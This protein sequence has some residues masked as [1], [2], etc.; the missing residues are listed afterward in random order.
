MVETIH[1]M[2]GE[3]R[4][5][6]QAIELDTLA[7]S[8]EDALK[9]VLA[10]SDL[11]D[12]EYITEIYYVAR[13]SEETGKPKSFAWKPFKKWDGHLYFDVGLAPSPRASKKTEQHI[14]KF[15]DDKQTRM[16][17]KQERVYTVRYVPEI[18][19][20]EGTTRSYFLFERID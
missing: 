8:Q 16:F 5:T 1:A 17:K 10:W 15:I 3:V 9:C 11:L 18:H 19:F 2:E 12:L 13:Y 20:Q 14:F 7:E 4:F 6:Q